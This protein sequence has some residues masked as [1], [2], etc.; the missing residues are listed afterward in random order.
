MSFLS[1]D[2][3]QNDS[4]LTVFLTKGKR[5]FHVSILSLVR[6]GN[7][8]ASG[9]VSYGQASTYRSCPTYYVTVLVFVCPYVHTT[10]ALWSYQNN[11]YIFKISTTI[12]PRYKKNSMLYLKSGSLIPEYNRGWDYTGRLHGYSTFPFYSAGFAET[13]EVKWI[14]NDRKNLEMH[15]H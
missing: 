6:L 3:S 9:R 15:I 2:F 12:S 5:V 7:G 4:C 14:S 10:L 1:S 8:F 11:M 13:M